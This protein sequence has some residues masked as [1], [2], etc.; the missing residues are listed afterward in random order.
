MCLV[1]SQP[2][3]F[4]EQGRP[5]HGL[6]CL[7]RI[8]AMNITRKAH[9]VLMSAYGPPE[10]LTWREVA[11]PPLGPNEVRIRTIA[12]AV[13]HT[14]LEI[15]AGNW[16]VRKPDPFPYVP[17]V[18]VVGEIAE[19]GEAVHD[20]RQGDR[21][22]TMMQGLGGLRAERTGGYAEYVTVAAAAVAPLPPE[23]DPYDMAAT[24][25]G[26]VTAY[27]GLRR[28][29]PLAGRQILVTGAAGGVGSAATAIARAQNASVIGLVSRSE[30]VE[31][32]RGLGADRV[33]VF[34]KREP[35]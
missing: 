3:E 15:R 5:Q 10:A 4:H 24:G 18:E 28:I 23:V 17:G 7:K 2:L 20:L 8:A 12:A 34:S 26:G 16:P 25:L 35:P 6:A 33:I 29:G 11:V 13:N 9:A 1:S 32:V 30:Q 19:V 27:E 14:D 22:I 31:Y 21:V